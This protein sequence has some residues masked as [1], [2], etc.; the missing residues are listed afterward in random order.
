MKNRM[1]RVENGKKR[2]VSGLET[3]VPVYEVFKEV[4]F[5]NKNI[6]M[7]GEEVSIEK[8]LL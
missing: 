5:M 2:P 3:P 8:E 7:K 6:V 4:K 1:L